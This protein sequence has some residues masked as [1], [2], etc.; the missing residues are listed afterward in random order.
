MPADVTVEE[1]ELALKDVFDPEIP[2][3]IVDLGLIYGI[4]IDDGGH[5]HVD[6][7][8]TAAGCGM[9]PFIA[10]QAEWAVAEV[11][12]VK[13]VDVEITFEPAW[14]PEKITEDGRK[15]LGLDD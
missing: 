9:G 1:V 4:E 7:T 12:G 13:D 6:M 2:V 14:S 11:D 5:V 15:L 8:L 3:N 10:Q